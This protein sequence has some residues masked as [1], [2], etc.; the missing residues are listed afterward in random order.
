MKTEIKSFM[1]ELCDI[2]TSSGNRFTLNILFINCYLLKI[3]EPIFIT[4]YFI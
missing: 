3:G 4:P 1:Y 2:N